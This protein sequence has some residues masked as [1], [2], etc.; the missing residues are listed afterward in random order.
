MKLLQFPFFFQCIVFKIFDLIKGVYL[1]VGHISMLGLMQKT[2][3]LTICFSILVSDF[4]VL[5]KTHY[6]RIIS[7]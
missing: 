5:L 3:L 2:T 4:A 6:S 7:I 1:L